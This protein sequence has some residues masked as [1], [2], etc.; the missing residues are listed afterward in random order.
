MKQNRSRNSLR[1]PFPVWTELALKS[2]EMIVASAQVISHRTRRMAAAGAMPSERDRR[3]FTLMGQEKI[4]AAGESAQAMFQHVVANQHLASRA[5]QQML[6]G[7]TAMMSLAASPTVAQSRKRQA[8]LVRSMKHSAVGAAQLSTS[9]ARL[10][11][12]GLKPIHSRAT[13]NAKRL[14]KR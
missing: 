3:E 14:A 6:A 5:F 2:A 4:A 7:A 10:A 11:Q 13:A 9:V 12:R 8:Q 1:N